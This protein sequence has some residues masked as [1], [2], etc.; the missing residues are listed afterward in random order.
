MVGGGDLML[1]Q[2]LERNRRFWTVTLFQLT[3]IGSPLPTFQ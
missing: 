3:L 2:P 1:G